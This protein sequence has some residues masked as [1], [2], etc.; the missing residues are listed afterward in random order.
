MMMQPP[1]SD[2]LEQYLDSIQRL[3]LTVDDP[4][5]KQELSDVSDALESGS[6]TLGTALFWEHNEAR[7]I[8]RKA[9]SDADFLIIRLEK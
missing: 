9:F 7:K 4:E 5:L 2:L 1:G 8:L 6:I 3:I